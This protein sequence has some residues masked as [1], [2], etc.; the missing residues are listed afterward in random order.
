MKRRLCKFRQRAYHGNSLER[1]GNREIGRETIRRCHICCGYVVGKRWTLEIKYRYSNQN[2]KYS[3]MYLASFKSLETCHLHH[4]CTKYM[5]Q[6]FK[7]TSVSIKI[8]EQ[9]FWLISRLLR[10][11]VGHQ[12]RFS[13]HL[14]SAI[15]AAIATTSMERPCEQGNSHD[16]VRQKYSTPIRIPRFFPSHSPVLLKAVRAKHLNPMKAEDNVKVLCSIIISAAR[17]LTSNN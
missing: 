1:E 4:C 10:Q 3:S 16:L 14:I 15:S 12:S 8:F 6:V 17:L 9:W 2:A 5:V 13:L 11:T 7:Y